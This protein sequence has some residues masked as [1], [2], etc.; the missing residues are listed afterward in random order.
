MFQTQVSVSNEMNI[1]FRPFSSGK[2][3]HIL[4]K[5]G[6]DNPT[7][8][9]RNIYQIRAGVTFAARII[10]LTPSLQNCQQQ[11]GNRSVFRQYTAA[12]VD[13]WHST[14]ISAG[15]DDYKLCQHKHL[16]PLHN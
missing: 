8:Y 13:H 7:L 1:L 14:N 3:R 2:N 11:Q 4:M 12:V 9:R 16:E 15:S 5:Y 6:Y 10:Y